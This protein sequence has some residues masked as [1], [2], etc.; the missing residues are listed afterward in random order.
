M[1]LDK[2]FFKPDIEFT[3]PAKEGPSS[4]AV[5]KDQSV[6]S[7]PLA[8]MTAGMLVAQIFFAPIAT[9]A[10]P[11]LL[12]QT[13]ADRRPST[14]RD[15]AVNDRLRTVVGRLARREMPE[16]DPTL[17]AKA[18]AVAEAIRLAPFDRKVAIETGTNFVRSFND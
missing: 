1:M 3:G 14:R 4:A 5:P 8:A 9:T 16:A 2:E 10:S 18:E 11:E 12:K 13:R 15:A 17:L 7:W 6:L